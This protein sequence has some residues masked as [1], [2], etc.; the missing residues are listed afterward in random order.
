MSFQSLT[1]EGHICP[2]SPVM[3]EI[4]DAEINTVDLL[5]VD[6]LDG[7]CVAHIYCM[8]MLLHVLTA[9]VF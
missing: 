7:T 4:S 9:A 5:A 6:W 8:K 3:V 2:S 1:S